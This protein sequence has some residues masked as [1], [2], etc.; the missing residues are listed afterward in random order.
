MQCKWKMECSKSMNSDLSKT[1]AG[2][3]TEN[4]SSEHDN[5]NSNDTV[6]NNNTE[7]QETK[8]NLSLE[9]PSLAE[10]LADNLALIPPSLLINIDKQKS[11]IKNTTTEKPNNDTEV[12]KGSGD[13]PQ[14]PQLEPKSK[15]TTTKKPAANDVTKE[16]SKDKPQRPLIRVYATPLPLPEYPVQCKQAR[17]RRPKPLAPGEQDPPDPPN[18]IPIP[19]AK[20]LHWECR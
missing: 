3:S 11:K 4:S 10:C 2:S 5:N 13:L 7:T 9:I 14:R 20:C 12:A 19:R 8:V 16:S 17:K 1:A 6:V 18:A 15:N